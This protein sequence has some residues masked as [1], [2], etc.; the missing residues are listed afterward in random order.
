[1]AYNRIY[2][3]G[4]SIRNNVIF[5]MG[6]GGKL[7]QAYK[8]CQFVTFSNWFKIPHI[9]DGLH[10]DKVTWD[11]SSCIMSSNGGGTSFI[12]KFLSSSPNP[13]GNVLANPTN[14]VTPLFDLT[15]CAKYWIGSWAWHSSQM[16]H[17]MMCWLEA[18]Y[19]I[20]WELLIFER[21]LLA[22][23]IGLQLVHWACNQI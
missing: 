16:L 21:R 12:S 4:P 22:I 20:L 7:Y 2:L 1:M 9:G 8:T 11:E 3:S 14:M 5:A 15:P 13:Q 17:P 23:D 6:V 18:L 19:C 10:V